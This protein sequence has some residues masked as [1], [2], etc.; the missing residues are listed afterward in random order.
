MLMFMCM[1]L[2]FVCGGGVACVWDC[3]CVAVRGC[4]CCFVVGV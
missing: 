1:C 2:L 4:C 3:V